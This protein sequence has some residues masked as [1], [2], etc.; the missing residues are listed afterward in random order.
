MKCLVSL[1][2]QGPTS[3]SQA[4]QGPVPVALGP[5]P[6]KPISDSYWTLSIIPH[7]Q[8]V[9]QNNRLPACNLTNEDTECSPI[10]NKKLHS[11]GSFGNCIHMELMFKMFLS[12]VQFTKKIKCERNVK[13]SWNYHQKKMENLNLKSGRTIHVRIVFLGQCPSIQEWQQG[14]QAPL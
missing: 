2:T 9:L 13:I 3:L 14:M 4:H 5:G 10:K 12:L 1:S 11:F 7:Q 6:K 8:T